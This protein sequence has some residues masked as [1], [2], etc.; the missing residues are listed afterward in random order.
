MILKYDGISFGKIS[1]GK[2]G[3]FNWKPLKYNDKWVQNAR[4]S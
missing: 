3:G 2:N 4:N 1:T